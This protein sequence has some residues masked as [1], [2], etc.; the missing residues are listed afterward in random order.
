MC[1]ENYLV[2]KSNFLKYFLLSFG[3]AIYLATLPID[4]FID[5]DNYIDY[6]TFSSVILSSNIEQGLNV[7]F[8]NEPLWLLINTLLGLILSPE[9]TLIILIFISS[10]ITFYITFVNSKP[11]LFILILLFLLLPQVLKNNIIHI[12]QGLAIAIFLLAWFSESKKYSLILMFCAPLI[13]SSFF[14]V[15]MILIYSK[16]MEKINFSNGINISLFIF[17]GIIFSLSIMF[18]ASYLGARQGSE[19]GAGL[20]ISGAGF[21]F[22]LCILFICLL[23]GKSFFIKNKIS[24]YF[25]IFYLVSYFLIP[26]SAR[27]FES[28]LIIVLLSTTYFT[29]YRKLSFI[30]FFLLYFLIQWLTRLDKPG[31]GWGIENYI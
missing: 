9:N 20:D 16:C 19:G 28:V 18:F 3:V 30:A 14:I 21:I 13:H 24:I 29:G 11:E 26:T 25:I 12:R 23:E 4:A 1:N 31:F 15:C 7:V 22:W 8:F 27:I 17:L 6:A 10:F 5:R 2:V